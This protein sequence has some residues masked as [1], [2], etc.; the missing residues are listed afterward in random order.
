MNPQCTPNLSPPPPLRNYSPTT[1]CFLDPMYLDYPLAPTPPP[2]GKTPGRSNH[3]YLFPLFILA[4]P[5]PLPSSNTETISLTTEQLALI[6][7]LN[8]YNSQPPHHSP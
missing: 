2:P 1:F 5:P 3:Q 6:F 4:T 7:F 8:P